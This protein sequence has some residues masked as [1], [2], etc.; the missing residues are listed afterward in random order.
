MD[1]PFELTLF[2]LREF[3]RV[4]YHRFRTSRL[5]WEPLW[6]IQNRTSPRKA[7]LMVPLDLSGSLLELLGLTFGA[8]G[9]T[10]G[11]S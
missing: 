7:Y 10:F 3:L 4:P 9:V 2:D 6:A 11:A 1:G 8:P 5:D